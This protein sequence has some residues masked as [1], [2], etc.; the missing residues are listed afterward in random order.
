MWGIQWAVGLY[1]TVTVL[2][3]GITQIH[4]RKMVP[5][6]APLY[7]I[8]KVDEFTADG[9]IHPPLLSDD[10]RWQR[11]IF[12]SDARL[13]PKMV[14]T[15]QEMNGQFSIPYIA[16][17]DDGALS[18]KSPSTADL[19]SFGVVH[20][21]VGAMLNGVPGNALLKYNRLSPDAMILEGQ[22]N[23]HWLRVRL[24]KEERQF[25]LK[26]RRFHWITEDEDVAF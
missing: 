11:V 5:V 23:G 7:G 3:S 16:T 22:M 20:M 19:E 2:S 1:A 12:D 14:A 26:A 25:T 4:L 9:E 15:I 13:S 21:K 6:T 17:P 10:L 8:W 18:L 24:T